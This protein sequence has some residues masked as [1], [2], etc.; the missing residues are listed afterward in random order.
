MQTLA[1]KVVPRQED[2]SLK[3]VGLKSQ[4]RQNI[5]SREISV[6]VYLHDHLDVEFV[7]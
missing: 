3:I 7:L 6:K 1:R 5:C 4:V 2:I